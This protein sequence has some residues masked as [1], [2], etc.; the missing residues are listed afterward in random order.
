MSINEQ[1]MKK[2]LN[3]LLSQPEQTKELFNILE[4]KIRERQKS[5]NNA[6]ILIESLKPLLK[7]YPHYSTIFD[8]VNS[9]LTSN[10]EYNDTFQFINYILE[11]L[12]LKGQDQK[13]LS[14]VE[15]EHDP[16]YL[17]T[18]KDRKNLDWLNDY[19]KHN[20]VEDIG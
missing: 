3:D 15:L 16:Q 5:I 11:I 7:D 2:L 17:F 8:I 9:I 13:P 4:L 6:Q 10:K 18:E 20:D 12:V 1:N 14:D 19:F